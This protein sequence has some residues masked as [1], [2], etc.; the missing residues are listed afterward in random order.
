[1]P[2]ERIL[3]TACLWERGVHARDSFGF[4]AEVVARASPSNRTCSSLLD[5]KPHSAHLLHQ[6]AHGKAATLPVLARPASSNHPLLEARRLSRLQVP[7]READP[8]R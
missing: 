3:K 2:K 6:P 5:F 1:M 4:M 7:R 8:T